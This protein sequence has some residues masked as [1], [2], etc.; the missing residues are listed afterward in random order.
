M[1]SIREAESFIRGTVRQL[2]GDIFV[3]SV[4]LRDVWA[5]VYGCYRGQLGWYVKVYESDDGL[6]VISH[7]EPEQP[8]VTITGQMIYPV[9]P[10][11]SATAAL[12]EDGN[13]HS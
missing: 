10:S 3:E 9:K 12:N 2:T 6:A 5:D 11:G 7:H 1:V 4:R 13:G 8:L